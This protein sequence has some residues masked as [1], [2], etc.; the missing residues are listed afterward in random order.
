[1]KLGIMQPYFFPYIGY[2]ALINV[3]DHFIF[4]D[5][6]Q[7]I[8]HGWIDRNR[9][10]KPGGGWQYIK[11]PIKK[12]K[13]N[14]A[15]KD[16]VISEDHNWKE[17]ILGQLNHYKN[18]ATYYD[19]TIRFLKKVF[20]YHS[21]SIS[22]INIYVLAALCDYLQIKHEFSVLSEMN[23]NIG[24]VNEPDEWALEITKAFGAPGYVNPVGGKGLFDVAKYDRDNI[25]FFFM[26]EFKG[27]YN[28][29]RQEFEPGLS[30]IDMLMFNPREKVR[31]MIQG[32]SCKKQV[33]ANK[34]IK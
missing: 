5:T 16:V 9:I 22:E 30:I 8:R 31:K 2:F 15:I 33:I 29:N 4:F 27:Q 25:E 12:H 18:I 19:E 20:L 21:Q 13:R 17:K 14:T 24:A 23:L 1:M 26:N 10:L 34:S 11:V 6:A 28:Q 7:F 3:V 32:T